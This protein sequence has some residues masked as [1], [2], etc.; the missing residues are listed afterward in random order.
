MFHKWLNCVNNVGV[1][2]IRSEVQNHIRLRDEVFVG[3]N[4][5]PV[6]SCAKV[7][8]ALLCNRCF[9]K[10]VGNIQAAVTEVQAL[11]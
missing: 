9:T 1:L 8:G 10:C 7:R 2:L 11:V 3:T 5:E 6:F 4:R